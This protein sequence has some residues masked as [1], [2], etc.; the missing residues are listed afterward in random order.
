MCNEIKGTYIDVLGEYSG[1]RGFWIGLSVQRAGPHASSLLV[2]RAL[3][4]SRT[5]YRL[6]HFY[7]SEFRNVFLKNYFIQKTNICD[8]YYKD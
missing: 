8:N 1:V 6:R 2:K 7:V 3:D 4:S 5:S